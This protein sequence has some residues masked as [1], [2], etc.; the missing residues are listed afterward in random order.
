MKP[1]AVDILDTN[2]LPLKARKE[3]ITKPTK[4]FQNWLVATQ[5]DDIKFNVGPRHRIKT[6]ITSHR[7]MDLLYSTTPVKTDNVE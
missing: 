2:S 4:R 7:K 3:N 6:T 1:A 5:P